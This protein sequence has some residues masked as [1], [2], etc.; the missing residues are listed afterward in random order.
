[1]WQSNIWSNEINF[2]DLNDIPN[3]TILNKFSSVDNVVYKDITNN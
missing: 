3:S 1:M 2:R